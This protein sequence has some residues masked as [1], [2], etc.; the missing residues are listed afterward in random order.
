MHY[1]LYVCALWCRGRSPRIHFCSGGS[2]K[3]WCKYW[4]LQPIKYDVNIYAT[5]CMQYD[6]LAICD[7]SNGL[8]TALHGQCGLDKIIALEG[9][10]YF[11][12]DLRSWALALGFLWRSLESAWKIVTIACF[13]VCILVL[14]FL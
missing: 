11:L 1:V 12:W 6:L 7:Q 2:S 14:I 4:Y 10:M 3:L 9:T 8:D 5:F 13:R